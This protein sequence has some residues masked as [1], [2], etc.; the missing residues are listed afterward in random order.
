MTFQTIG[1]YN[2]SALVTTFNIKNNHT[3][4]SE[5][6]SEPREKGSRP[7]LKDLVRRLSPFKAKKSESL[8]SDE[9][10]DTFTDSKPLSSNE[11]T[12]MFA[13]FLIVH[14]SFVLEL[15]LRQLLFEIIIFVSLVLVQD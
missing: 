1:T 11:E 8:S 13:D 3:S 12:D 5:I 4:W 2:T 9:V 14:K 10:S 6:W 7:E 15:K